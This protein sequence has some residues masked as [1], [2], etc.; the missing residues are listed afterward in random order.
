MIGAA[1][2][3]AAEMLVSEDKEF[4]KLTLTVFEFEDPQIEILDP[5]REASHILVA[6][7]WLK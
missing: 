2:H 1:G 3:V 4:T 5:R 7:S 6:E